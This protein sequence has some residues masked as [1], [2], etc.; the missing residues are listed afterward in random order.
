MRE[1]QVRQELRNKMDATREEMKTRVNEKSLKLIPPGT[2]W[3]A[4]VCYII[5]FHNIICMFRLKSREMKR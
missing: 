1:K 4:L 2:L 3:Q 5:V